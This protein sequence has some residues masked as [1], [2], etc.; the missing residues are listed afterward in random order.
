MPEPTPGELMHNVGI[1]KQ[2]L[3][4]R[5]ESLLGP[6]NAAFHNITLRMPRFSSPELGF[7]QAVTWLYGF[8]HESGRITLPF[9][10]ERFQ[11]YDLP[12]EHRQHYHDLRDLRTLLQHNL[13]LDST[14]DLEVRLTCERWFADRCGSV[15][16]GSEIEW[17][18][19]LLQL[20]S[21]ANA[22]VSTVVKCV[23]EVER[24]ESRMTVVGQWQLRLNRHHSRQEFEGIVSVV[25]RDLGQ[26][27]LDVSRI[28]DRYY[29]KW[30][31]SLL[32]RTGGYDFRFEARKLVEQ[33]LLSDTDLPLP[34]SGEDVM[35][36]FGMG[37]GQ[38]IGHLLRRART[39]Y[40]SDPCT[41]DE[42]L[43]RLVEAVRSQKAE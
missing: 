23:R 8:Y 18:Q 42:L 17:Q 36:L 34:I 32:L 27:S 38:R 26:D 20:L 4:Q 16:P 43:V 9:L 11:A 21:D 19:C 39:I 5:S 28:C 31:R 2:E 12:D 6:P 24:D 1:H 3:E 33:T 40:I 29:D 35:Q 7:I 41:R 37:P 30:N 25:A 15:M 10:L 22:F 13:S 14:H